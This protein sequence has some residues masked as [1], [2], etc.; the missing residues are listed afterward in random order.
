[1][2]LAF[3]THTALAALT[4]QFGRRS[5]P[6]PTEPVQSIFTTDFA[7][8]RTLQLGS[9]SSKSL[10]KTYGLRVAKPVRVLRVIE[11][12]SA[13]FG[14][15]RLVMSGRMADVCAELDRLVALEAT[16]Q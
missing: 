6:K 4:K 5:A 15:G 7:T 8:S 2:N 3:I 11:R 12:D 10:Q 14:H 1:M 9:Y 16:A 13:H